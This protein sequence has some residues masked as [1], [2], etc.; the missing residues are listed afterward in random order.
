[1]SWLD[2][3]MGGDDGGRGG[4]QGAPDSVR[5]VAERLDG[6]DDARAHQ[7]AA[8]ACVLARVASADLQIADDERA[9]MERVLRE[10]SG[11]SEEEARLAVEA[12]S[13]QSERR[14]ATEHYLATRAFRERSTRAERARLVDCVFAVAAADGRIGTDE[15]HVGLG[16]AEELGFSRSEALGLRARWRDSLAELGARGTGSGEDA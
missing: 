6:L 13:A 5:R 9:A 14:G 15:S 1:M 8:L 10:H 16:I 11:L 12:A 3:L 7:V 2:R 4:S